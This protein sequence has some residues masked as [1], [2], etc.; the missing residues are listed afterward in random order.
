MPKKPGP[1][2]FNEIQYPLS[3]EVG[4]QLDVYLSQTYS[5]GDD[6]KKFI[7]LRF[8]SE[9]ISTITCGIPVTQALGLAEFIKGYV[10]ELE[11]IDAA[12]E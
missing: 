8:V 10:E 3:L 2:T 7:D 9:G 6:A 1:G 5:K 4:S 11:E 12:E